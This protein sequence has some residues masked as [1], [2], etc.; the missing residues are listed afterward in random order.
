MNLEEAIKRKYEPKFAPIE[1]TT[2]TNK[3][4]AEYLGLSDEF[5]YKLVRQKQIP[6]MRVG[7]RIL[8]K[9]AS[10]DKWLSDLENEPII[11][12]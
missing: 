5:I 7:R 10:I 4:V 11:P 1:R 6:F 2:M 9:K 12:E 8:F 3:E